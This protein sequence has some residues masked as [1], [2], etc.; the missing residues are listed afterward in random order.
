MAGERRIK[1]QNPNSKEGSRLKDQCSI[2]FVTPGWLRIGHW[3]LNFREWLLAILIPHRQ[4][5]CGT[6]QAGS[7]CYQDQV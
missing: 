4:D 1:F 2:S 7:L 3:S 6:A 5:A